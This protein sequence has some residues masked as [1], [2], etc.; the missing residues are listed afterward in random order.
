MFRLLGAVSFPLLAIFTLAQVTSQPVP[1]SDPQAVSLA[2]KS[3]AA[4]TSGIGISDVTINA[5]VT[6]ILG[7]D[8]E[9]GIG[10]LRAKGTAE[11]RIDF[12]LANGTHSE[13]RS[14]TN[15]IPTGAWSTNGTA[16]TAM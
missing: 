6:S 2:Q 1:T 3:I 11:S 16:S 4:L 5:N 12:S 8:N 7:S 13:V 14:A 9:I 10:M 15:G